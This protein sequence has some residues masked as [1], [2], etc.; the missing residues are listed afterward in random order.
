MTKQQALV[1]LSALAHET[2]LEAFKLLIKAAPVGIP[3][4]ELAD[5]LGVLQNTM[6]THLGILERA[7]LIHR[8]RE[9]RAIR[10]SADV[11][12]MQHLLTYLLQDCCQGDE[13]VCA[14][15]FEA[16]RCAC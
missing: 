8:D 7:G 1:A 9:G 2:R 10:C 16:V 6:S 13:A 15:L 14:P 11:T 4:G 3:A 12:G 5:E